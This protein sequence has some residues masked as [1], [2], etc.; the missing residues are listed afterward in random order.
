MPHR[1]GFQA[2]RKKGIT[3][4][5]AEVKKAGKFSWNSTARTLETQSYIARRFEK[6]AK[7]PAPMILAHRNNAQKNQETLEFHPKEKNER[8]EKKT[9][10][11]WR[12]RPKI[13]AAKNLLSLRPVQP[14][15]FFGLANFAE[16]SQGN[17]LRAH[18]KYWEDIKFFYV[19]S[20]IF[21]S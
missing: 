4:A 14:V 19:D 16:Q 21:L 20:K 6:A 3:N 12:P 15:K 10:K 9:Q 8:N 11:D 13:M 5:P 17:I 1:S 18:A 7:D 2:A